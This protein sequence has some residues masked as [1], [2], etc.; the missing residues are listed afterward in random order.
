MMRRS[1]AGLTLAELMVVIAVAAVLLTLGV[2]G[3]R[4]FILMQ[5]LKG[6]NAQL[7][8]DLQFAR[9]E[10]AARNQWARVAF[11]ADDTMTCY[12]IY[13]IPSMQDKSRCNCL[14]GPGAA[15]TGAQVEIR[16]VQV[17][18]SEGVHVEVFR[19]RWNIELAFA[20]DHITGGIVAIPTDRPTGALDS[21][22]VRSAIDGERMLQTEVGVAGRVSVCAPVSTAVGAP[23]CA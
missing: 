16:T 19:D 14:L 9:S 1:S 3:F 7:V 15:C 13:T 12:S 22:K 17:K 2:P 6:I 11:R 10:A 5:R 21:F 4:D 20:Y 18:R 23:P 8:T